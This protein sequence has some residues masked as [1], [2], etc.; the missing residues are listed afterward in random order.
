MAPPN[1]P[2]EGA[3]RAAKASLI[4]AW[5]FRAGPPSFVTPED[6]AVIEAPLLLADRRYLSVEELMEEAHTLAHGLSGLG[7]A[8]PDPED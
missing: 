2:S 6:A 5:L 4:Q 3:R 1:Y 8:E 7:V